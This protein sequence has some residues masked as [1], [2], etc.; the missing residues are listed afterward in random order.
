MHFKFYLIWNNMNKA[1]TQFLSPWK[2]CRLSWN[3]KLQRWLI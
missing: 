2:L 1:L 3:L